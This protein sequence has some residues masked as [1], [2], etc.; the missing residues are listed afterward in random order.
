MSLVRRA[1]EEAKK[2]NY[3]DMDEDAPGDTP[4]RRTKKSLAELAIEQANYI[5][6]NGEEKRGLT[7][8]KSRRP[9]GDSVEEPF[10][11]F[12]RVSDSP[13]APKRIPTKSWFGNWFGTKC[14]TR[15]SYDF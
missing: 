12:Q 6:D 4:V 5:R 10:E 9:I 8:L 14:D 2:N 1:M 13:Q 3:M 11:K 7:S 15:S